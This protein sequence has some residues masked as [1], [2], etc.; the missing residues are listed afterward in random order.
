MESGMINDNTA[1]S[2]HFLQ[3]TQAQGI[4]QVPANT[5]G[6]NIDGIM[7]PPEGISDQR[8]DQVTS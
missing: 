6:N 8:H 5:L 4:S 2:H 3:I 1:L 7:Q